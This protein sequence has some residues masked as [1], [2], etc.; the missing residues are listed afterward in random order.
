LSSTSSKNG[1]S[2]KACGKGGDTVFLSPGFWNKLC[3]LVAG[4]DKSQQPNQ[5]IHHDE[6]RQA[7]VD[8]RGDDDQTVPIGASAHASSKLVKDAT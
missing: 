2:G 5:W 1:L 3:H 4:K 8:I 7:F 6:H